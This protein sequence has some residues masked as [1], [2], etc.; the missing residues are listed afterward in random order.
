[1]LGDIPRKLLMF[2]LITMCSIAFVVVVGGVVWAVKRA[3]K[4]NESNSVKVIVLTLAS[5]IIAAASWI[6]NFGW[7][8]FFMTLLAIPIIHG[9]VYFAA[10]LVFA[11]YTNDSAKMRKLNGF[12]I[13]TYLISYLF[14]PDGGDVGEMYFF[15]TLIRNDILS[16]IAYFVSSV[17]FI[18]HIVLFVMQIVQ[19]IKIKRNKT[20]RGL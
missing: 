2:L 18:G 12:F 11:K 5:M 16:G 20:E 3:R 13:V 4:N 1:M 15:F 9:L 7:I 6:F 14:F 8:R 10:N 17:A 19:I